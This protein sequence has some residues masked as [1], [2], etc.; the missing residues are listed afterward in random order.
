M[1]GLY[2]FQMTRNIVIKNNYN[3]IAVP[4]QSW[5]A[6]FKSVAREERLLHTAREYLDN[7]N[8]NNDLHSIFLKATQD[9]INYS[10]FNCACAIFCAYLKSPAQSQSSTSHIEYLSPL[11]SFCNSNSSILKQGRHNLDAITYFNC[12][13]CIHYNIVSR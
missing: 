8:I 9:S 12:H 7:K 10:R 1:P 13:D 3:T 6:R 5:P 2:F 4:H 11:P